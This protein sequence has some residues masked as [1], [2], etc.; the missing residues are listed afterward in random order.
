MILTNLTLTDFGTF[1]GEQH[2]ALQPKKAR[3]IVLFGGKNG[4]GKS[5]LLE[6]IRLCFYGSGATGARSKDEYMRYLDQRIHTNANALIQPTSAS[7]AIEFQYGDVDG[8]RTYLVTRSWE[9]KSFRED[10][11]RSASGTRR[12]V[13]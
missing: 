13:S 12:Q 6:A 7:V 3:P 1:G 8:L 11:G 2:I 4:A 9:R 5:T 10:R